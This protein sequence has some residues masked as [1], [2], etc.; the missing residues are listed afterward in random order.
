MLSPEGALYNILKADAAVTALCSTRIYPGPIP[1]PRPIPAIIHWRVD[2]REIPLFGPQKRGELISFEFR[3]IACAAT[4]PEVLNLH[5]AMVN[6][7]T[8]F[9]RGTVTDGLSPSQSIDVETI[10]DIHGD[11]SS[12]NPAVNVW[13]MNS[14][15][16][17]NCYIPFPT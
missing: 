5:E 11:I 10:S 14:G 12:F 6:A 9:T 8:K 3:L 1:Q 17:I 7:L 15:V 2:R 4:H 16:A 13:E